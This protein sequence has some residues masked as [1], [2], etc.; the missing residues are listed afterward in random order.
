M[1]I[2]SKPKQSR[3]HVL[4]H[5]VTAPGLHALREDLLRAVQVDKDGPDVV[6][7]D[8]GRQA[9]WQALETTGRDAW[10]AEGEVATS[11]GT[12]APKG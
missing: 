9:F 10:R 5:V 1:P 12:S 11:Q 8:V 4:L 6:L 7:L 2:G 3:T